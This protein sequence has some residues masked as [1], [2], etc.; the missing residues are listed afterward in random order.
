MQV[1]LGLLCLHYWH[2]RIIIIFSAVSPQCDSSWEENAAD[3][4][5][6]G[7]VPGTS[8]GVRSIAISL[9]WLFI[10]PYSPMQMVWDVDQVT[11]DKLGHKITLR[12]SCYIATYW[13]WKYYIEKMKHFINIT[14]AQGAVTHLWVFFLRKKESCR[15]AKIMVTKLYSLFLEH[16]YSYNKAM[17]IV[18][19]EFSK[20][21][22]S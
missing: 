7:L 9:P 3:Y 2:S 22:K 12:K 17:L 20:C 6:F 5:C 1:R 19:I 13:S 18:F 15:V 10:I 8:R 4:W 11:G 14:Y 21:F 16:F